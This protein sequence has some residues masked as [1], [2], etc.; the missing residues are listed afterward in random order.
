MMSN[1]QITYM[2]AK[3]LYETEV[4]EQKRLE[5][6]WL[7]SVGARNEDGTTPAS[8]WSYDGPEEDFDRICT[9]YEKSV[10]MQAAAMRVDLAL[11]DLK[12]TEDKLIDFALSI[13]PANIRDVLQANRRKWEVRQKII[14]LAFR[15]D[16]STL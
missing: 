10:S 2:A 11:K 9:A 8:L 3:A 1:E 13:A 12:Q 15:L 5:K 6:A 14:D 7:E 16:T 4:Q